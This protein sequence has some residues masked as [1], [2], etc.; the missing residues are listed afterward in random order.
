MTYSLE[1]LE[2]Q[3]RKLVLCT[4]SW[5][6]G[7]SLETRADPSGVLA[8]KRRIGRFEIDYA[9]RYLALPR[10][11]AWGLVQTVQGD[12]RVYRL[13]ILRCDARM[14][15]LEERQLCGIDHAEQ[16]RLYLHGFPPGCSSADRVKQGLARW[17]LGRWRKATLVLGV[18][19]YWRGRR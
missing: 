11:L 19:R 16:R 6:L 17:H 13:S 12:P 1:D 10:S 7:P 5:T 15:I 18:V 14:C 9:F 8:R 3:Y 4:V 2:R